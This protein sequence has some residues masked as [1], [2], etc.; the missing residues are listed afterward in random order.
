MDHAA[1]WADLSVASFNLCH[2][3]VSQGGHDVPDEK[4]RS[5]YARTLDNLQAAIAR[6]PHVLIYDNSDLSA[7]DRRAAAFHHGRLSQLLGAVPEWLQ[8]RMP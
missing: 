1:R 3:R 8:P 6:L 5:R 7:P 4:L 2:V